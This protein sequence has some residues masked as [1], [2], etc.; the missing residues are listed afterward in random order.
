[1]QLCTMNDW[2]NLLVA[3]TKRYVASFCYNEDS[4]LFRLTDGIDTYDE[5]LQCTE[6]LDRCSTLNPSMDYATLRDLFR[7]IHKFLFSK[8]GRVETEKDKDFFRL[9]ISGNVDPNSG[10]QWTFNLKKDAMGILAKEL[11]KT[12]SR[13]VAENEYLKKTVRG[14][15]LHILD[16]EGSGATLSRKT[17]KTKP[18]DENDLKTLP[19]PSIGAN[20]FLDILTTLQYKDLQQRISLESTMIDSPEVL[21]GNDTRK[22]VT[23]KGMKRG[24]L[25]HDDLDDNIESP[26]KE[27]HHEAPSSS[28]RITQKKDAAARRFKKL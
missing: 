14:K 2:K 6:I 13:L 25:F 21:V 23:K 16:L 18:F 12:A 28:K 1:M 19:L 9:N 20:Q 17:L 5:K 24:I 11:L 15:D 27:V 3:G 7:D 26:T 22:T 10:F 4:Y 8:S